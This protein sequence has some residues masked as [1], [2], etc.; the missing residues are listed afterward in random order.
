M[1]P[2]HPVAL[3]LVII[4]LVVDGSGWDLLPDPLG[5]LLVLLGT[6]ALPPT[7]RRRGALLTSAA[8]ALVVA[9]VVWPPAVAERIAATDDALSWALSLPQLAYLLLLADAARHA[10]GQAG[11]RGRAAWFAVAEFLA[12]AAA[13][14]PVL[15]L[16]GGLDALAGTAVLTATLALALMVVLTVATARAPWLGGHPRDLPDPGRGA[17]RGPAS[18]PDRH[19]GTKTGED[20]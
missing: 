1:I 8:L 7:V 16:G 4:A 15:V 11:D 13:L 9:A 5:W 20:S 19:S 10:A 2:L 12:A 18:G 14:L 6:R 17:P 3:G